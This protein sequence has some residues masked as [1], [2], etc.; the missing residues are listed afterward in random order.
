MPG[1]RLSP[2]LFIMVMTVIMHDSIPALGRAP[3]DAYRDGS[4]YDVLYADDTLILGSGASNVE[5]LATSVEKVGGAYGMTLHCT[6][7]QAFSVCTTDQVL[8]PDGTVILESW[9]LQYLGAT[10]YGDGRADSELSR[11]LGAARADFQQLH[12]L[13]S[14]ANVA[15]KDKVQYFQA[16]VVARLTYGLSSLWLVTAQQRR[17]DGFYARCLRRILHIPAA[18]VSRVPNVTVLN[19]A[20][21]VPL[22][23]QLLLRQLTLLGKVAHI[24]EASPLK[25][26]TL[27]P[28]TLQA[29][30]ARSVRRIGQPCQNWTE[31]LLKIGTER[32]GVERLRARKGDG[33]MH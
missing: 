6:K 15:R 21:V 22:S 3:A 19:L 17:L 32:L 33:E 23:E 12:K 28:G 2:F 8:R 27:V 14:H 31:E 29:Q 10:I 18:Y 11:K 4:L 16:L 7:T 24:Q 9:V 13:R 5:A 1:V 26:D 20:G 30:V 25:R